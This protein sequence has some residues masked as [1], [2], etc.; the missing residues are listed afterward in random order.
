MFKTHTQKYDNCGKGGRRNEF[1]RK[2][3]KRGNTLVMSIALASLPERHQKL[4]GMNKTLEKAVPSV[5]L[6]VDSL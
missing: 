6:C 3:G 2:T 4:R 1:H 5:R